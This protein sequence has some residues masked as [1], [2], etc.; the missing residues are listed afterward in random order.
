MKTFIRAFNEEDA[1][2][3]VKVLIQNGFMVKV[4]QTDETIEETIIEFGKK[5]RE[6]GWQE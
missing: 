4:Y 1:M 3:V 6:N 2:V 5:E